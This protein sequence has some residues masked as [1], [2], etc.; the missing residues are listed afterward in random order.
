[1]DT[2]AQD[3]PRELEGGCGG[4]TEET[5]I[6]RL[7]HLNMVYVITPYTHDSKL[8]MNLR[9]AGAMRLT[10]W[11]ISQGVSAV[12]PIVHCHP[13]ANR[14]EMPVDSQFW[15]IYNLGLCQVS[16][17]FVCCKLDLETIVDSTGC[18]MELDFFEMEGICG[19]V[20]EETTPRMEYNL[21]ELFHG[22]DTE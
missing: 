10:A 1:M 3:G 16:S 21:T 12:S 2:K 7:K 8:I 18:C 15:K 19:Y 9:Y 14:Y 20:A 11:L 17:A 6:D 22:K 4:R 13:L 5:P